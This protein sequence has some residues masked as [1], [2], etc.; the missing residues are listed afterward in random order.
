MNLPIQ[1]GRSVAR[2]S[3]RNLDTN[4]NMINKQ[5]RTAIY[6]RLSLE[7]SRKDCGE[8]IEN[9][10]EYLKSYIK[11]TVDLRLEQ[12]YCD[13][14]FTG[15]NF[16]RPEWN[17]LMEDV[18]N[19]KI[20][21]ILVKDLSRVGRD[22]I[23]TGEYL[24]TIFPALSVR[25]ISVND[26]YDSNNPNC[27]KESIRITLINLMNSLYAKDISRKVS[28][29]LNIKLQRGDY[30]GSHPPYGYLFSEEGNH[31]LIIDEEAS[32]IVRQ[33]FIWKVNEYSDSEIAKELNQRRISTPNVH[34]YKL[35]LIQS[36]RYN[37]KMYWHNSTIKR[38]TENQVYIGN[39]IRGKSKESL[40]HNIA[41]HEVPKTEW[42]IVKHMH[43][44]IISEAMFQTVQQIRMNVRKCRGK[45]TPLEHK[46][47]D[48]IE[49]GNYVNEP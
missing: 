25:F 18:K 5:Y 8:S 1:G 43:E 20:N 24:E 14:G 41:Y 42:T 26:K 39:I 44:A 38:I 19:G 30:Q 15:T 10:M 48:Y 13:N 21:C 49:R 32:E 34:F 22:Y 46:L 4:T 2:K 16:Q 29:T 47:E 23:E 37:Q 11:D 28:A 17:R 33:I 9:Q 3:R 35:G 31:K 7:D 36:E 40:Y 6:I 45:L 27:M 12:I